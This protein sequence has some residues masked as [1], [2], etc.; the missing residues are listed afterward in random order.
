MTTFLYV[1]F[2]IIGIVLLIKGADFFVDGASRVAKAL[3]VPSLII[4]LTIVSIGTSLPEASVSINAVVGGNY[5]ISVANVVGSNIAN[6]WLILGLSAVFVP[7]AISK[8]MKRYDIPILLAL[9]AMFAVMC[10]VTTPYVIDRIEAIIMLVIFIAYLVFL[11]LR[12]IKTAPKLDENPEGE[13]VAEKK[14]KL[15]WLAIVLGVIGLG[16]VIFGGT[17]VVDS[18]SYIAEKLGM[19]QNLIGLTVVAVGT[20]LPELVTSVIAA[21]KK[22]GDIA[23][24][25]VVGSNIF[26]LVFILGM[27]GTI[28]PITL[29]PEIWF[30]FI[31]MALAMVA[32]FAIAMFS[33]NMT[34]WQGITFAVVYVVYI[35]LIILRETVGIF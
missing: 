18:A 8:D 14:E 28:S 3:K 31:V 30:D 27:S 24:G 26:N 1:L 23:I 4:G 6:V 33:K 32:V 11:V 21:I 22:E 9:Y 15:L 2:L 5:A 19:S 17:C 13:E 29:V 12:A 35:A 34:R 16:A 10:F 25:N 20:S 7:L